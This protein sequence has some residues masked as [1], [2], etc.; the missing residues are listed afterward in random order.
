VSTQITK[1]VAGFFRAKTGLD[2]FDFAYSN[3]NATQILSA[4]DSMNPLD[5]RLPDEDP[6][7]TYIRLMKTPQYLY[8]AARAL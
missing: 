8:W 1:E 4:A 5:M 6:A 3:L 7:Y 2:I